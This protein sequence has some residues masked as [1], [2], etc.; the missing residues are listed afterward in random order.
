MLLASLDSCL[1]QWNVQVSARVGGFDI[2]WNPLTNVPSIN[3]LVV[4]NATGTDIQNFTMVTNGT[5]VRITYLRTE[6][7]YSIQVIGFSPTTVNPVKYSCAQLK[8]TKKG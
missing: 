8:K 2:S 5:S 4:Y 6:T 7:L 1:S 3:Y